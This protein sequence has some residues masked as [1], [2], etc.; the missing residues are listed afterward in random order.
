[1]S[2]FVTNIS[3]AVEPAFSASGAYVKG[4]VVLYQ[5]TYWKCIADTATSGRWI[6]SEWEE[7]ESLTDGLRDVDDLNVY[8]GGEV[9]DTIA[10]SS[11]VLKKTKDGV[12]DDDAKGVVKGTAELWNTSN[13]ALTDTIEEFIPRTTR[14]VIDLGPSAE[15]TLY[16]GPQTVTGFVLNAAFWKGCYD[17]N[18]I[19]Q[20]NNPDFVLKEIKFP[21]YNPA[22]RQ[23]R[24]RIIDGS[25]GDQLL[26]SPYQ[27][28]AIMT[29][30][31]NPAYNIDVELSATVTLEDIWHREFYIYVETSS[32][33]A[34][35]SI[36]YFTRKSG[37]TTDTAKFLAN[38]YSQE[39]SDF[40]VA[41]S[42]LECLVTGAFRYTGTGVV[43]EVIEDEKSAVSSGGVYSC[44]L[45]KLDTDISNLNTQ[46]TESLLVATTGFERYAEDTEYSEGDITVKDGKLRRYKDGEWSEVTI[47]VLLSEKES[48][49]ADPAIKLVEK[50]DKSTQEALL[51]EDV[52]ISAIQTVLLTI[53]NLNKE[54]A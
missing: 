8:T 6:G 46:G 10:V 32:G 17:D 36:P 34:F 38:S 39:I 15:R 7:K 33:A 37:L 16:S 53:L 50:L 4:D 26:L 18:V 23:G 40:N 43:D 13:T 44:L 41:E 48:S 21:W 12:L 11:E 30:T 3:P 5:S 54:Q 25:N 2:T 51:D 52:D 31:E 49:T 9:T 45:S 35:S 22:A 24:I 1:M 27:T 20:E 14:S 28:V 42:T 19:A 29:D 47:K